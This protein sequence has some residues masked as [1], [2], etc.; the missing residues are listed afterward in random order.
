M[1]IS[2][3]LTLKMI[4]SLNIAKSLFDFTNFK[5]T[6]FYLV[7]E[8]IFALH[9]FL[10]PKNWILETLWK[11]ISVLNVCVFLYISLRKILFQRR[12]KVLSG[13]ECDGEGR[14][15]GR[16]NNF[17]KAACCLGLAQC[18]T[19]FHFIWYFWKLGYFLGFR[20]FYL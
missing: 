11:Y 10:T 12:S 6:C 1:R 3:H 17:L 2:T 18:F 19:I 8:K 4:C 9:H 7:S 5:Q 14:G 15:V 13:K 16:L 20:Y